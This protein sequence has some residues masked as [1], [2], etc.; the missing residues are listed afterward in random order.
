MSH[1]VLHRVRGDRAPRRCRD[2]G[3]PHP[4]G[5]R[6]Q[7]PDTM[8][9]PRQYGVGL[10]A[11]VIN[12]PVTHS[13]SL[14]RDVDRVQ[15]ISGFSLTEAT[16][17]GYLRRLHDALAAWEEAA[18]SHLPD[19]PALHADE[20]GFRVVRRAAP[21]CDPPSAPKIDPPVPASPSGQ[22]A[23]SVATGVRERDGDGGTRGA[24]GSGGRGTLAPP[25]GGC[26]ASGPCPR[27]GYRSRWRREGS[28]PRVASASSI[29]FGAGA[30]AGDTS[31]TPL[32]MTHQPSWR[33]LHRFPAPC[34]RKPA[35]ARSR[36]SCR[37]GVRTAGPTSAAALARQKGDEPL[38]SG[39]G[40]AATS[41]VC[42]SGFLP[43]SPGGSFS[44]AS[45]CR[46]SRIRRSVSAAR[47][48]MY[49]AS[50][51][52]RLAVSGRRKRRISSTNAGDRTMARAL[53]AAACSQDGSAR[54]SRN[55]ARSRSPRT[56]VPFPA[57]QRMS[58][59]SRWRGRF[60]VANEVGNATSL[61]A[62]TS[63]R[64]WTCTSNLKSRST[65]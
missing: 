21:K 32:A 22:V 31:A 49:C 61:L 52:V 41:T 43:A 42:R 51:S 29:L 25:A 40:L 46:L 26:A 45:P 12:L 5:T 37:V 30:C 44:S 28:V 10:Q 27:S 62:R 38:S 48:S 56:V 7:F 50:S 4:P 6:E 47:N 18:I 57:S 53:A 39:S 8:A 15:A 1:P 55:L 36:P 11:C 9:G 58:Q 17:P 34:H 65:P 60:R 33:T 13:L 2:E 59:I 24:S 20:T 19:R 3:V 16:C 64:L 63:S 35:F 54:W 23:V 14:H